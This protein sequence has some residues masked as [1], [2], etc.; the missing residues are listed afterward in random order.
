Q[1]EKAKQ[2]NPGTQNHAAKA[3]KELADH[4][5]VST[6]SERTCIVS[7]RS[8]VVC[9]RRSTS[10]G[11]RWGRGGGAPREGAV[12]SREPPIATGK[13]IVRQRPVRVGVLGVIFEGLAKP[14]QCILDGAGPQ[15]DLADLTLQGRVLRRPRQE[16]R[17]EIMQ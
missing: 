8:K 13:V 1:Q 4:G 3:A 7:A 6:K 5:N 16:F 2:D 17:G 9:V 15:K 10:G 12:V 11:R 14:Q